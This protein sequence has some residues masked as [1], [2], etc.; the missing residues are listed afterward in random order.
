MAEG[1]V[2][3]ATFQPT[4]PAQPVVR[5]PAKPASGT[6]RTRLGEAVGYEPESSGAA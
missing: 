3:G 6:R 1:I 4:D 2:V 5:P